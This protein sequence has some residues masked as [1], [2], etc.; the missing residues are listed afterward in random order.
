MNLRL[1]EGRAESAVEW[2][3]CTLYC[4]YTGA[5]ELWV[6]G[7]LEAQHRS[8]APVQPFGNSDSLICPSCLLST[9]VFLSPKNLSQPFKENRQQNFVEYHVCV[10]REKVETLMGIGILRSLIHSGN[11]DGTAD[12]YIRFGTFSISILIQ[13][14]SENILKA[15]WHRVATFKPGKNGKFG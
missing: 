4:L 13:R 5:L 9:S 8:G 6:V 7:R 11:L 14:N 15:F 12:G 10:C 1:K 3:I 2:P